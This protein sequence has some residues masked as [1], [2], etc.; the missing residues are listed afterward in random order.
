MPPAPQTVTVVGAGISGLAVCHF[1]RQRNPQIHLRLVEA[2]KRPGGWLQSHKTNSGN[3]SCTTDNNKAGHVYE[4]GPRTLTARGDKLRSLMSLIQSTKLENELLTAPADLER[5][6]VVDGTLK[7]LPKSLLSAIMD[8]VVRSAATHAFKDMLTPPSTSQIS[9]ASSSGDM[10]VSEM[11]RKMIGDKATASLVQG[12]INGVYAGD[13]DRWS[14]RMLLPEG[15]HLPAPG[16]SYWLS[17]LK[18]QQHLKQQQ[19]PDRHALDGKL[20][21]FRQGMATLSQAIAE[22]LQKD[23]QVQM[24]LGQPVRRL[25][26][27][28]AGVRCELDDGTQWTSDVVVSALPAYALSSVVPSLQPLLQTFTFK[29]LT[30]V[31]LAWNQPP[32]T[33]IPVLRPTMGYLQSDP[34]MPECGV[35]VDSYLYPSRQPPEST[36]MTVI[37]KSN[38]RE[39]KE[40]WANKALE[41]L[42]QRLQVTATPVDVRVDTHDQC[43]PQYTVGHLDR[44]KQVEEECKRLFGGR[45]KVT[46]ASFRGISVPDCIHRASLTAHEMT[47]EL[48][49]QQQLYQA[50]CKQEP[51][52]A[53]L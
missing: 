6:L 12:F 30:T 33:L 8:P 10:A 1:L 29:S 51:Q 24:V 7:K 46:G 44:V 36:V 22:Q 34:A 28:D 27:S 37:L 52:R 32:Q 9:T 17:F 20:I 11:M 14:A 13:A 47:A 50:E 38:E 40:Q 18:Q 31:S 26:P 49:Q 43:M 16:T 53:I 39:S 45:M 4:L 25:V 48:Q 23:D 5:Y 3:T 41:V 21:S 42:K 19:K 15:M 2:C 35:I